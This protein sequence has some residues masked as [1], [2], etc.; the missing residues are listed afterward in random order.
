VLGTS[1]CTFCDTISFSPV[2]S[3]QDSVLEQLET[4]IAKSIHRYNKF[5]A[6][7]QPYSNTYASVHILKSLFEPVISDPRVV[8]L[9]LGTRPDC[10]TSEIIEYCADLNSR[11]YL[12]IEL[13]LQS[14]HDTTLK[15]INRG[16]TF[17]Q[18]VQTVS[19]LVEKGISIVVHI[20]LGLPGE[21]P[22]MMIETAKRLAELP[23]NGIKFHQ[24]MIIDKTQLYEEYRSGQVVPLSVSEYAVIVSACIQQMRTDQYIH[25]LCAQAKQTDGLIAPLWS[26]EKQS[27]IQVIHS[28]MEQHQIVQGKV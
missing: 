21:S 17:S 18:F 8:G 23:I 25:R 22:E 7:F 14:S 10:F 16:H 3:R 27:S 15:L 26:E 20:I 4:G 5:I 2:A 11:T 1:G 13:G 6:Y 24:L 9:A 12:T 28:Y 19:V